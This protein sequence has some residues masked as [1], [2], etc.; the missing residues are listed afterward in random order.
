MKKSEPPHNLEARINLIDCSTSGRCSCVV[1][2]E[3]YCHH[4]VGLLYCMAHCKQLCL[5][6]VPD[7]LT[8]TSMPQRWSIPREK[9][10]EPK[11]IQEILVKKPKVD[12]NNNKFIKSTIYSPSDVY[13]TMTKENFDTFEIKPLIVSI[14][15]RAEKL[16]SMPLENSKYGK[17]LMGSILSYQQKLSEVYVMNDFSCTNFPELPLDSAETRFDNSVST[18]LTQKQQSSLDALSLTKEVSL[19]IQEKTATQSAN[20][21]WHMLRR[22]RITAS[23][24]GLVA[25]RV[26]DFENLIKQLN[27]SRH[28]VTV[29][30]RRCIN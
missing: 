16:A 23:K 30:M 29:P 13:C 18:A 21:L 19:E 20:S 15:P 12:A 22:N 11:E 8:C 10:I 2:V 14:P 1:G 7:A 28:V 24:F 17:V 6:S 4:V 9:K 27:P 25:R 5:R 3:G 26:R